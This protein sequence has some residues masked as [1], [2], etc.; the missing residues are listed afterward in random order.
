[1]EDMNRAIKESVLDALPVHKYVKKSGGSDDDDDDDGCNNPPDECI[2]CMIE[3][4]KDDDIRM[5]PCMHS[6]HK[7][8][9]RQLEIGFGVSYRFDL[10][11][12]DKW[13]L[14]KS[15]TCPYCMEPV[16]QSLKESTKV[17]L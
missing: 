11:C 2:I 17:S 10:E 12:V 15:F 14:M 6:F 1:M 16:D 3:F 4:D 8:C 7:D 5:L 13:L 9:V